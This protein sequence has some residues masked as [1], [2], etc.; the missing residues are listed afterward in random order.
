MAV[1]LGAALGS[2]CWAP[3]RNS[4]GRPAREEGEA[5]LGLGEVDQRSGIVPQRHAPAG[6]AD[7]EI[8]MAPAEAGGEASRTLMVAEAEALE[9]ALRDDHPSHEDLRQKAIS[10]HF[11]AEHARFHPHRTNLTLS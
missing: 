4:T 7:A 1:P 2:E 10:Q 9:L 5:V 3:C 6:A 11:A 8:G